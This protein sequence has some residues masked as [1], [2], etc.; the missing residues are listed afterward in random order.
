MN[1]KW[2]IKKIGEIC[3]VIAG[4]SPEGR[5]YN[6][7]G[8][9]L[10]FY[11]GKKEF[12]KKYIGKPTVWTTKITKEAQEG[13]ILMSVRAPVG[14]TNFATEK[15]CIGRGLAL[16]RVNKL[17]DKDFLFNFFQMY[18]SEITG[19]SGAVFNSINK[20][21]IKNIEIPLP[22]IAE[23][24]RI[25][26]TLNE[27]FTKIETVKK[28]AEKN[29]YNSKELFESNLQNVFSGSKKHWTKNTLK[30]ATTKIGSGATPRG[31]KESY[32]KDGISLIRSMNVHD[33]FFKE[34]NLAFI[35]EKQAKDL[36]NVTLERGDVL[37]NITGASIARCCV[38]LDKYLPGR[39]NQ[40]VSIIRP[41][42]EVVDSIFLNYLLT[43]K[44]YK[45]QLLGIG[46][47][48]ATRQAITKT[49]LENFIIFLPKLK[50][51]KIIVKKLNELS[52]QTKKLEKIYTQKLAILE[53][54]KKSVLKKAFTGML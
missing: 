46:E 52:I 49:Q 44:Y 7:S 53:E 38:F 25:V 48:G 12:N 36:L 23:Q 51:Q 13:D 16:I 28:N 33:R 34:K 4:Q 41:K 14:P 11:Q 30:G 26:K 20:S 29:L 15:I 50:E 17:V 39:V 22:V 40:H 10:P 31:G 18:E 37:L 21:Q 24:K 1:T 35:D 43:S 2:Q 54:L 8:N 9:G 32:K 3:D 5:F 42:K 45:D 19:N 47:Q 6:K 27:V